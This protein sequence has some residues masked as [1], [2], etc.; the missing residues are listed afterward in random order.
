MDNQ[1]SL[2]IAPV[3]H[4]LDAN[5]HYRKV[6]AFDF[7]GDARS[8]LGSEPITLALLNSYGRSGLH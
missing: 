4:R 3:Y 5:G 1:W 8:V 2:P 6:F 7:N